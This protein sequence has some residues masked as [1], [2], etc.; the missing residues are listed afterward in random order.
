MK[1]FLYVNM[2]ADLFRE[3]LNNFLRPFV[4]IL[5]FSGLFLKTRKIKTR[6]NHRVRHLYIHYLLY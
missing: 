4:K 5:R 2:V 3:H 6:D 1:L